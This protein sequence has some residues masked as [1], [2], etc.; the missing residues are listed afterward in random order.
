MKYG[1]AAVL[2][3]YLMIGTASAQG[4]MI[5]EHEVLTLEESIFGPDQ[6]PETVRMRCGE[7]FLYAGADSELPLLTLMMKPLPSDRTNANLLIVM[8]KRNVEVRIDNQKN[9]PTVEM[10]QGP[11]LIL[12]I[13]RADYEKATRCLPRPQGA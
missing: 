3:F 13:S 6:N 11:K 9:R 1:A 4:T 7:H 5:P 8:Q 2:A 12:R 10:V